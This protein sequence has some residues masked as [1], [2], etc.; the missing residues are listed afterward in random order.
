MAYVQL[1]NDAVVM[2]FSVAQPGISQ[3]IADNDSRLL[4]FLARQAQAGRLSANI[5]G[6]CAISSTAMPVLN[7][8]WGLDSNTLDQ[9]GSVARDDACGLGLPLGLG[10]F[11]YPDKSST[12]VTMTGAQV[13][14]LYKA[15]RD[16]TMSFTQYVAGQTGSPPAQPF[17]IP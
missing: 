4:G 13:Q 16:Y 11:T 15:L 12:P 14:A 9:I 5:T 17:V 7:T 3:E 10:T 6:G 8:T 1:V 2:V